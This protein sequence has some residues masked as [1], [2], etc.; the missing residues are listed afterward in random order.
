MK[1]G[2]FRGVRSIVVEEADEPEVTS[3][4][5]VIDV[6]ACGICGSG[7]HGF[8]AG[9]FALPGQIM[10]HEFAGDV[11]AVG[12]EVDGIALGD[13]VSAMPLLPCWTCPACRAGEVQLCVRAFDPGIGY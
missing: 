1:A 10:G 11:I 13:R 9:M 8:T 5:I 6:R 12:P 3:T 7:L 2:V 4:G